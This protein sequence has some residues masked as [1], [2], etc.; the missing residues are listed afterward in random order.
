MDESDAALEADTLDL[1]KHVFKVRYR[2]IIKNSPAL[3]VF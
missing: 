3:A 2:R 1:E